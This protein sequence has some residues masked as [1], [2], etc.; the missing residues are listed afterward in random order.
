MKDIVDLIFGGQKLTAIFGYWPS[1]H[2]AEV[3][4]VHLWRGRVDPSRKIFKF[5]VLTLK[6]L[7]HELTNEIDPTGH[8]ILQ[9]QTLTTL[10]FRGFTQLHLNNFDYQN[11]ITGL[12]IFVRQGAEGSK[13]SFC[14][15]IENGDSGMTASFDCLEIEVIDAS[16]CGKDGEGS[17]EVGEEVDALEYH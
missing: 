13:P 8:M 6:M 3:L 10:K 15:E 16:P 11:M 9:H 4:D 17:F 2:D 7:V 12:S 1:F 5:P 14:V